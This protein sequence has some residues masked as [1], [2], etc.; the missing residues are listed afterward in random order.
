MLNF[1][2]RSTTQRRIAGVCGGLSEHF[3]ISA[4]LIRAGFLLLM[5]PG[6]VPGPLLYI[7]CII[8]MPQGN[9][10]TPN[11]FYHNRSDF[12]SDDYDKTIDI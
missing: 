5:L 1:P 12:N 7:L 4:S 2:A 11:D 3:G 8:L 10:P 6:G 9:Y